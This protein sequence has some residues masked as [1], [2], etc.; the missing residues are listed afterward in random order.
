M[1]KEYS[2]LYIDDDPENLI[3]FEL[4]FSGHFQIITAESTEKAYKYLKENSIGVVLV[5]YKMPHEDGISFARRVRHEFPDIVFI[6]ISAWAEIDVVLDAINANSFYGFIQKPWNHNELRIT[7]KNALSQFI[8]EIENKRLNSLLV[9]KNAE[10]EAA[11]VREKEA[12]RVKN[13]FLQSISHEVRT[14]LN[15]I[16][17]FSNLIKENAEDDTI[18]T[19]ANFVT[20]SG[21]L[22][23]STIHGILEASLIF[24]NQLSRNDTSFCIGTLVEKVIADTK[25]NCTNPIEVINHVRKGLHIENDKLKVERILSELVC[26]A[27]K[28]TE[29][30]CITVECTEG[31]DDILV[32]EVKD[33]GIGIEPEKLPQI[34]QPFRQSDET[35]SRCYNGNGIGLFIAKSYAE[36]LGGDLCVESKLGKGSSFFFSVKG[37]A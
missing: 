7:L 19:F 14:P 18:R 12:N 33:T 13:V 26:N 10:L 31:N 5:D 23:L 29:H 28:F 25:L 16:I 11:L 22:L 36:F 4:S 24:T 30:G 2:I 9:C 21:Y 35:M 17:G 15:S 3:G 32:F 34:F 20:Q 1:S 27:I 37:F 6:M 8:S